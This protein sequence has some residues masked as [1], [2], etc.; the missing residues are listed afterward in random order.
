MKKLIIDDPKFCGE[1]PCCRV[2]T[3][4]WGDIS[5]AVCQARSDMDIRPYMDGE[6]GTPSKCPLEDCDDCPS[7]MSEDDETRLRILR[8]Q[9]TANEDHRRNGLITD[10]EYLDTLNRVGMEIVALE[11]KYGLYEEL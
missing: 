11:E 6:C 1:C 8:Q 4:F 7:K 2:E 3:G 9:F 5:R 10:A